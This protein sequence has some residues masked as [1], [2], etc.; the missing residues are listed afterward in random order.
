[1][2][3]ALAMTLG[4]LLLAG[5]AA[6]AFAASQVDFSGHYRAIFGNEWN[7]NFNSGDAKDND[8]AFQNRLR[9]NFTFQPTE[10]IAVHWRLHA[11]DGQRWGT[12]AAQTGAETAYVFGEIKQ[13]WGTIVIGRLSDDYT[14]YGLGMMGHNWGGVDDT[15][16]DWGIFDIA[17]EADG[18]TYLNRW[19]N[20]FQLVAQ[21]L[22]AANGPG[23]INT[24]WQTN[25]YFILQPSFHWDDGGASLGL[26]YNRDHVRDITDRTEADRPA[27]KAFFLNP[28]VTH[29]FGDFTFNFEAMFGWGKDDGALPGTPDKN[30]G[31]G[32][33]LDG[34]YN[35]GPGNVML[36]GWWVSGSKANSDKG[37]HLVDMGEGFY[38]LMVAYG[39]G[40]FTGDANAIEVANSGTPSGEARNNKAN[41]WG[42]ALA[43][44]H[45]FTDDFA[46]KYTL[47][48]LW[49]NTVGGS[50]KGKSIGT[51]I[52]LG[53]AVQLLDN[54]EFRS[55]A[56]ILFAGNGL[57]HLDL[58]A[59]PPLLS[60]KSKNAYNWYNTLYFS[61]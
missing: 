41:H 4:A 34:D 14:Y 15:Y 27:L 7:N 40:P 45:N 2:K 58:Q 28:A 16:T 1:M 26:I 56:G 38:P 23:A 46:L 30:D 48:H 10:E 21:F 50:G 59:Q 61:F 43:G 5:S 9:L 18:I 11:P 36:A 29:S 53:I 42:L 60:D 24:N 54:L 44:S 13:D 6:P 47:G 39:P 32:F 37:K 17:G 8:S 3:K 20:G 33:Y 51:E 55:T 35:Y 25:D 52:D 49:L 22:R 31:Y 57:R 12:G 19:D